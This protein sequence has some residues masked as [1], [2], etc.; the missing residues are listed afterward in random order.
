M[1]QNFYMLVRRGKVQRIKVTKDGKPT[2]VWPVAETHA[3]AKRLAIWCGKPGVRVAQIGSVER[4]TLEGHLRL[5][6]SEGC[7]AVCCVRDW[8]PDGSPLWKWLPLD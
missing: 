4:E 1:N 3:D 8:A 6:I 2:L 7:V 5:A